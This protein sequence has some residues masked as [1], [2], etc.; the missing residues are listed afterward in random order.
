MES[1]INGYW[2][3][4]VFC[5]TIDELKATDPNVSI[6]LNITFGCQQFLWIILWHAHGGTRVRKCASAFYLS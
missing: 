4:N 1:F 2:E 5:E 3:G 6:V